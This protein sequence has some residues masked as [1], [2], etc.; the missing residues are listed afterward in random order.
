MRRF[1]QRLVGISAVGL[2]CMLAVGA[3]PAA[4]DTSPPTATASFAEPTDGN[5]PWRITAPQTL[6]L[7]ATDDVAVAG[8]QYSLDG[9]LTYLDA[10]IT[11]GAS[12]SANVPLSLEGNTAVR[13]RAV[14]S[15]GNVSRGATANTTLNQPAAAGA[16]AIRL[17][18]TTG[19]S[20]GDE[21]VIGTG[22]S[23][24]TATID[25][26]VTPAPPSPAAN[27]TL[28]APLANAHAAGTAVAA[29][30]LFGA[31]TLQLDTQGPVATWATQ[32]TTLQA[33]SSTGDTGVRLAS[34]AGRAVD[35]LLVLDQAGNA[36]TVRIASIVSPAPP[37]P[38]P[39]VTL[40]TPVQ[41]L[42]LAGSAVYV[43][44][45][46]DG[47]VMQSQTLTPLR[48]DPR[49]RDASDTVANGAGGSAIRR[50]IVDGE[51]MIPFP[52]ALNNLTVGRHTQSVAL[53]DTAGSVAKYTNTFVVTTSFDDLGVV[54]DQYADNALRTTL[55]G[56]SA[57][58]ATALRL[59]TPFGFRAGQQIVIDSG[60]N[61]ETATIAKALSPPPT[62]NTTLSAAAS[63][64]DTEV[65]IASYTTSDTAGPNAPSNNGPIAGQPIVLDT[66]ANL[67]VVSVERH[68]TPV[69]PAPAPNVVLSAPLAKDHAAGT[70]TNVSNVILSEPLQKAHAGGA[71]VINPRP[72]IPADLAAELKDL[73]AQASTAADAGNKG[74]A[75]STLNRFN[76]AV[77]GGLT[78]A[79][80]KRTE[81]AA[82][83]SAANALID[84][85][86]GVAVDTSGTGVE[87]GPADDGDQ[88][89]RAFW[90]PSPLMADPGADYK[91]LVNG[92]AGGFRH[93]S[94]VDFE[95]L[96]QELGLENNF[97]VDVWDPNIGATP[98]R[99]APAGVSLTE[100]PF[101][102]LEALKQY[103][104]IVFNSTVGR[105]A[106]ALNAIEFANLQQYIR[107]GGGVVSLHGAVDS[108]Q[109]VPWY[110]DLV[111]AGFTN[112][113][114]NAGGILI[115]TESGGH[116][117]LINADPGHFTTSAVPDRFVTVEEVYNLNRDPVEM[118]IVHPLMYENEDSLVGQI[119]YSTG[120][121]MN[122]DR[123]AMTWC[124]NFEGG[125]S[126]STVL[127]H[128]WQFALQPWWQEMLLS[129][130]EWS[131]GLEYANCVSFSEVSDAI[132]AAAAVG[133][134]T[135]AGEARLSGL[136]SDGRA[137]FDGS[138]YGGAATTFRELVNAV[139]QEA[140]GAS[141][142]GLAAK[143]E[144][145][146]AW[147]KG[148]R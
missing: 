134:L 11:S 27:V 61:Q 137:Q 100:S 127:G 33:T 131:A 60:D 59:Q 72:R 52:L 102:N 62:L 64:G 53:Q 28:R 22:A 133:D 20:A 89:I 75:V 57:V 116:V 7:T 48:T 73:L 95:A 107:E 142:A 78:P 35:D 44:S 101:M 140:T 80:A 96:I 114:G 65:R 55:N 130:I 132:E 8:L 143:G 145:L 66:G 34:T 112:H 138:D 117:E 92:R 56:A 98:G 94:I 99:Q 147:A 68:I 121:L 5:G 81:R 37:A 50:M 128:S 38:A 84:Q 105:G 3:A 42:H 118:G 77:L 97:D 106:Q 123:H 31:I 36:E 146:V 2:G 16:T 110:M 54:V 15:S 125:R 12:V 70:A 45:I 119:G 63:A 113:G 51:Q 91:V 10:A 129:A 79:H 71:A 39:N 4:A 122:T 104:T 86:N 144:E 40:S 32:A 85:V 23:Q 135:A 29:T 83:S 46:V 17:Q 103:K 74:R 24:E 141:R 19:R 41:K 26:I 82:L 67:E 126:F 87:V 49:R 93:Q 124:R 14:D 43:P 90:N 18:S 115:D 139:A 21:L 76:A 9:G 88:A 58:G 13:Y 69:P 148:L 108:M 6:Q 1:G 47:K 120:S 109:N 111:G 136:L 25:T 30:S